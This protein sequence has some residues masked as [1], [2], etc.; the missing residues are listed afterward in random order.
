M[1]SLSF[2]ILSSALLCACN[3]F[4][5]FAPTS[6]SILAS[7][8]ARNERKQPQIALYCYPTLGEHKC[9]Q[10]PIEGKDHLLLGAYIKGEDIYE[11][12]WWEKMALDD[13]SHISA[14]KI[15]KELGYAEI[16]YDLKTQTRF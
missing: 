3:P 8:Y 9:V 13:V 14:N 15:R 16:P 1:K 4:M 10:E 2:S 11:K 6:E 12:Q 5:G 7:N